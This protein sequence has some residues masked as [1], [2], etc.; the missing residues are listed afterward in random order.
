MNDQYWSAKNT[1]FLESSVEANL[2]GF[3]TS[4]LTYTVIQTSQLD[5]M[6]QNSVKRMTEERYKALVP[7]R[8]LQILIPFTKMTNPKD[9]WKK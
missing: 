7:A 1:Q 3:I 8:Y 2:T 6:L 9:S 5:N 4:S